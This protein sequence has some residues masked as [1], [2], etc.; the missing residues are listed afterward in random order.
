MSS[1][2]VRQAV[3]LREG[4]ETSLDISNS[5]RS[6]RFLDFARNDKSKDATR[7]F[8]KALTVYHDD[9]PHS[10]AMNM[11]ID[12]ALLEHATVPSIRFYR[13]HSPALSFGYFGKFADV[14][15]FATERD[16]VRRWTGGGIV[17]HGE[18]LTYSIVIPVND[19]IFAQSSMS[20]YEK[21]HRALRNALVTNGERAELAPV[22]G[23]VDARAAKLA[24]GTGV[25]E[26]SSNA[27]RGYS[28]FANPV[29]ADVM[30]N[31][32]KIAGAAQRRTRRGLLHQGSIQNVDL[33]NG[34]GER[35]ARALSTKCSERKIENDVLKQARDLAKQRY[36][37]ETWLR[38]R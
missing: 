27:D 5:R 15:G 37:T 16:L 11:A 29:R 3:A 25:S 38:K 9:I 19:P 18:D 22:A 7:S 34:L 31:G 14:A 6:Q 17:F 36:G 20:I 1:E 32:R 26:P 35:F 21:I 12:E 13:W 10:A 2:V 23:V 28:C 33:A 8:L 4:L 30:L 24:K